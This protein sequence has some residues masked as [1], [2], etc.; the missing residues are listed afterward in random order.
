MRELP[1]Q[2]DLNQ[3]RRQARELQRAAARGEVAASQKIQAT[4]LRAT[5]SS[6]QLALAR[7]YGFPSWARLKAEIERRALHSPGRPET[8]YVIRE[9]ATLAE[10]ATAFD[11]M[12]GQMSPSVTHDDRRFRD[13]AQRFPEDRA[14][15]LVVQDQ[16]R[17]VGGAFAFRKGGSGITLRIIALE[18]SARGLGLGRR[19]MEA[20]ELAALRIGAP[21]IN[22]GGATADIKGFY[23]H[24]GYG[25]RGTMMSKAL[26][27]PGRFLEA[28][29][30]RLKGA[31]GDLVLGDGPTTSHGAAC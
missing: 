31:A 15:M 23:N 21:G 28:K 2:P 20:V 10:L 14:L 29:L 25:G 19:L 26:P 18:L 11:V 24:L 5:L 6:A 7:E 12:A 22:L 8:H 4:S 30:R 3:L 1:D 16:S 13:L 9:A 27:A 17:I